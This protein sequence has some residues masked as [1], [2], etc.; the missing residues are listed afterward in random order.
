M[1]KTEAERVEVIRK[2][3]VSAMGGDGMALAGLIA[4]AGRGFKATFSLPPPG[5]CKVTNIYFDPNTGKVVCEV[6]KEIMP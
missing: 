6:D 5:M 1:S 2:G 3:V 4:G